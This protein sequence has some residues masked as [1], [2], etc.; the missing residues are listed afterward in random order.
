[1]KGVAVSSGFLWKLLPLLGK[2]FCNWAYKPIYG[3]LCHLSN[4]EST[5]SHP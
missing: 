1:M 2:K 5:N 4:C 3:L